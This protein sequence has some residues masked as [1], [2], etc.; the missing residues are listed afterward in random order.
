MGAGLGHAPFD[1]QQ[2]GKCA[3]G[4]DG[5]VANL[6]EGDAPTMDTADRLLRFLG[7]APIGPVFRREVEAFLDV[8]AVR[9]AR[10]GT[11]A[12]GY[13]WFVGA[14][15]EGGSPRLSA[16]QRV[17]AWMV[18]A[19]TPSQRAV[20]AGM[21]EDSGST[22]FNDGA[23][24]FMQGE[25]RERA[26]S[27]ASDAEK[28]ARDHA[29]KDHRQLFLT[30]IQAAK[31]L[32]LTTRTLERF[33]SAGKGPAYCKLGC[34]VYYARADLPTWAWS[35]RVNTDRRAPAPERH[36]QTASTA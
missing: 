4:D 34:R 7:E 26:T 19:V 17:R 22:T 16:V 25:R 20:I 24:T 2:F 21:L 12:A 10:L 14:L 3:V 8:T 15:E 9:P 11:E 30:K 23:S 6:R 33:R 18:E 13:P 36:C 27:P 31:F 32:G 29:P 35:Q 5:F 1:E 28:D